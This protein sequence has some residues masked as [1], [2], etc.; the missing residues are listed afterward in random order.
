MWISLLNIDPLEIVNHNR[1]MRRPLSNSE[2]YRFA[3]ASSEL[4]CLLEHHQ[5]RTTQIS[6]LT[7]LELSKQDYTRTKYFI[8]P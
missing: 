8:P 7:K 3:F 6:I 5:T 2:V 4:P 1:V